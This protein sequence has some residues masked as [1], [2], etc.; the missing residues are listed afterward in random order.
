VEIEDIGVPNN[1]TYTGCGASPSPASLTDGQQALS[2]SNITVAAL[3]TCTVEVTVTATNE[4]L[5]TNDTEN[6]FIGAID[7]QDDARH[8]G[9]DL[10]AVSTFFLYTQHYHGNLGFWY[11][12]NANI[13]PRDQ[14]TGCF[15]SHCI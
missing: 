11:S 9:G 10:Q 1:V 13:G 4:A 3:S 14:R 6:L 7:T 15:L 8:T 2:F 12:R 5:H